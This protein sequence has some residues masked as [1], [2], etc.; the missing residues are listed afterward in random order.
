MPLRGYSADRTRLRAW[1]DASAG[2]AC[3][4]RGRLESSSPG[5][6]PMPTA[7]TTWTTW[8]GCGGRRASSARGAGMAAGGLSPMVAISA[9]AAGADVSDGGDPLRSQAIAAHG[10]A[11]R[12]LD[13]RLP[14]GRRLG[15]EP[16]AFA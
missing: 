15:T 7:W 6:E 10:V 5:S 9:R 2:R 11:H 12:L 14:E 16:A 1:T 8:T 13:V 4:T 3:T